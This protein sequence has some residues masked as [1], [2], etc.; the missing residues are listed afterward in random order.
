MKPLFWLKSPAFKI[1]FLTYQFFVTVPG[2]FQ[3]EAAPF[4]PPIFPH[5][6]NL[7]HLSKFSSNIMILIYEYK[8]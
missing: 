8:Q 3:V 2:L 1:L 4:L 6:Y 5:L 7:L